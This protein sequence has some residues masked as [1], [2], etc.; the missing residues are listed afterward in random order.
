MIEPSEPS[1]QPS[2]IKSPQMAP[3]SIFRGPD[4]KHFAVVHRSQRDPLIND[5]EA[6]E[7]VLHPVQRPNE[8]KARHKK[9]QVSLIYL[10]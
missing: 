5:S 10:L 8:T 3:K 7:R 2:F 4:A 1:D 9:N 6:G